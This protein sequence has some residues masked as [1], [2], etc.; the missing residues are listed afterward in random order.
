MAIRTVDSGVALWPSL[1][2]EGGMEED[3]ETHG[4]VLRS[5]FDEV[6]EGERVKFVGVEGLLVAGC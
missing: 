1:E 6:V 2:E 5:E 3:T 4:V